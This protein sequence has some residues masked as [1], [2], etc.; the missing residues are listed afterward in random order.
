MEQTRINHTVPR[1]YRIAISHNSSTV[2]P[3]LKQREQECVVVQ[4]FQLEV[5][6]MLK[7]LLE[8]MK[9]MGS[10]QGVAVK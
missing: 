2:A 7:L 3:S 10:S 1:C 4:L 5:L 6:L 8:Q 9:Q